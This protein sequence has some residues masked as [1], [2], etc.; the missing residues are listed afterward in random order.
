MTEQNTMNR[1]IHAA[2][3]RDLER[4]TDALQSL[5]AGDVSRARE[6]QRAFAN[7]RDQLTHH[8]EGEDRWV[9]PML[10]GKGVDRGLLETMESEHA[11]M[12]RALADT[13]AAMSALARS[14]SAEDAAAAR[15]SMARTADVVGRHLDHEEA[16]VEPVL[17]TYAD[18]PEWKAVERKFARQ[19]PAVAGAFFAWVTDG[20]TDDDRAYLRAT[21]PPPVT[22]VLTRVFGRRYTREVA[23][24]WRTPAARGT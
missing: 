15:A 13:D 23:P 8:H 11:A 16:E 10:A 2:V 4:L 12:S 14:A 19:P 20:M 21:V 5:P 9:W 17:L 22:F 1:V 18:S 3:R 24:V 6:L 7:L